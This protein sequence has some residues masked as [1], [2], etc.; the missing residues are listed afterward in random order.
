MGK[1]KKSE[2]EKW[3]EKH[4]YGRF[5]CLSLKCEMKL[6]DC[7]NRAKGKQTH[8][9]TRVLGGN[10]RSSIQ[11]VSPKFA[12]CAK[13]E[14]FNGYKDDTPNIVIQNPYVTLPKEQRKLIKYATPTKTE[15]TT[16]ATWNI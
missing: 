9:M 14:L 2:L 4:K 10:G 3:K 11:I 5:C 6:E 13:C 12:S 16:Y 1:E 8:M 7:L 15:L